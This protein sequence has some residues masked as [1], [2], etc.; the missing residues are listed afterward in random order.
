[1]GRPTEI[2]EGIKPEPLCYTQISEFLAW[3]SY[4]KKPHRLPSL[5]RNICGNWTLLFPCLGDFGPE[6]EVEVSTHPAEVI[7][8][9]CPSPSLG[10]PQGPAQA[11]LHSVSHWP[12]RAP[13]SMVPSH[14]SSLGGTGGCGAGEGTGSPAA[15]SRLSIPSLF[16]AVTKP[17]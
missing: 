15:T 6:R 8:E 3:T 2:F 1:M 14:M 12:Q 11:V 9:H 10:M 16:L 5:V 13:T 7:S 4:R 17:T